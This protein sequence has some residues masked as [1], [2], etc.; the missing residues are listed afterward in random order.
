MTKRIY[1]VKISEYSLYF[2][3]P[4]LLITKRC[5][6]QLVMYIQTRTNGSLRVNITYHVIFTLRENRIH[7]IWFNSRYSQPLYQQ[8]F[9]KIWI[10]SFLTSSWIVNNESIA[11]C[12]KTYHVQWISLFPWI[13]L[14]QSDVLLARIK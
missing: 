1:M 11:A 9:S 8:I 7:D 6:V 12:L 14:F 2:Y 10:W 4:E 13:Q 5:R 3:Q